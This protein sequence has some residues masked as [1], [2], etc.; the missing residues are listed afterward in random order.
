MVRYA[1]SERFQIFG[2]VVF[3]VFLT[4][5]MVMLY[6]VDNLLMGVLFMGLAC[7]WGT[8]IIG[9]AIIGAIQSSKEPTK[10]SVHFHRWSWLNVSELTQICR[11]CEKTRI[12]G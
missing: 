7:G 11:R 10:P 9:T 1:L 8:A 2:L 12:V 3:G 5:E 4:L 6:V